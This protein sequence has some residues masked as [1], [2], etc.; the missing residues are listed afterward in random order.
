MAVR[1]KGS[2]IHNYSFLIRMFSASFVLVLLERS[3]RML[4]ILREDRKML[5]KNSLRFKSFFNGS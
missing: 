5:K 1:L 4:T 2:N 3:P